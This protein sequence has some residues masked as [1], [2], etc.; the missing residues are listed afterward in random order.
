MS[1]RKTES[2]RFKFRGITKVRED[3]PI[4]FFALDEPRILVGKTQGKKEQGEEQEEEFSK[5][6]IPC[7]RGTETAEENI[8][9][10]P[11]EWKQSEHGLSYMLRQ[12]RDRI[13]QSVQKSDIIFKGRKVVNPLFGVIPTQDEIEEELQTLLV[14]M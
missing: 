14:S 1:E 5:R 8:V 3:C 2:Y 11:D 6:F 9:A 4:M 12:R 13:T 7:Q 10:Y